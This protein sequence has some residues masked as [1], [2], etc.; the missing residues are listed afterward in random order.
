MQCLFGTGGIGRWTRGTR[1]TCPALTNWTDLLTVHTCLHRR[2]RLGESGIRIQHR[3][4]GIEQRRVSYPRCHIGFY[5]YRDTPANI[6]RGS[7][8][9]STSDRL[10]S[11]EQWTWTWTA[12]AEGGP[13]MW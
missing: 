6:G 3:C 5:A 2:R 9:A 10:I 13:P 8:V 12:W 1:G 4:H 11:L 7:I